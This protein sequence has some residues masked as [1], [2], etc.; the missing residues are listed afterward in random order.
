MKQP[1]QTKSVYRIVNDVNGKIYIGQSVDPERRFREHIGGYS[2]SKALCYAIQKYGV[3]AF[4]FDI[5]EENI[6]DYNAREKYWIAY[7]KSNDRNHGYNLTD[8]G[9]D[10]PT[11]Y[12]ETSSLCKYSDLLI[13]QVQNALIENELSYDEISNTFHIPYEML[14]PLNIGKYR[15]NPDLVYPLRFSGN[16]RKDRDCVL[17]VVDALMWEPVHMA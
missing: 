5:L 13:E 11:F 17:K 10:P 3:D 6:R 12:G 8:G 7:Y 15:A 1:P 14:T 16:E 2:H 9:E 4:S